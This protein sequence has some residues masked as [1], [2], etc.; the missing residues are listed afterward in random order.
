MDEGQRRKAENEAIFRQV[1][2]QIE[3]LQK[4]FALAD[5]EP[6]YIVC[7]CDRLPCSE[8]VTVPVDVYETI[9]A[10]PTQFFVRPGHEDKEIEDVLDTGGDYLVVRKHHGEPERVARETDPRA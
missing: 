5:S 6:L 1:N 7:E 3:Q 2:E 9:R 4:P 8:R 10:D